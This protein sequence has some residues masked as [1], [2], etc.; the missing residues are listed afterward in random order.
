MGSET[1]NEFATSD[2]VSKI[3]SFDLSVT[4]VNNRD[5]NFKKK[6]PRGELRASDSF[7]LSPGSTLGVK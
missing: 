6:T 5:K 3:A 4:V 7:I 2:F 1:N